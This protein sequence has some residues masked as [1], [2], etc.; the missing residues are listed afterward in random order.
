MSLEVSLGREGLP[1][2]NGLML[3]GERECVKLRWKELVSILFSFLLVLLFFC[4]FVLLL[5]SFALCSFVLFF[6]SFLFCSFLTSQPADISKDPYFF[7]NHLG[8]YECKLCLTLHNTEGNYLAHT[9]G[10]KHQNNQKR[11]G[12]FSFSFFI[13]LSPPYS[14]ASSYPFPLLFLVYS[15]P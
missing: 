10:K 12:S 1:L 11:R 4:S 8:S 13:F 6:C 14:L 15:C 9:Q 2:L 7:R 5:C 3:I